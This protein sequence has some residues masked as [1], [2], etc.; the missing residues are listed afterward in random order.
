VTDQDTSRTN[1][2]ASE[3]ES[4]LRYPG[5]RVVAAAFFGVMVGY[6]VL[7]PYTFSLFIK[8]LGTEFGWRRDQISVAL[9]CVAIT[10]AICSPLIGRLLDVFGPRRTILPCLMIFGLGFASLSFLTPSLLRFNLTFILLGLAGN[11]TTQLAYSRA[12][13]TWFFARRGMALSLV[14]AGAGAGAMILPLL[15]SWVLRTSGWRT[16]YGVLGLLVLAVGVPLTS[17][18]VRESQRTL[19]ER[20]RSSAPEST[21]S[22][23]WTRPFLLLVA[24]IFFYSV[25]FNGMI[26]HLS[27]LLTDRG[28]SLA[29]SAQALSV[30]GASGLVG[31]LATGLLLDRFFVVR[32]SLLFFAATAAGIVFLSLS[33]APSAFLGSAIIGFAAG[34]ES[35]ITPYLLSR[36][37]SL[38]RFST[39]YGIAWTAFAAGT[40]LGP[41]LMGRL[42]TS[43]G[44]YQPWGIE[45]FALPTLLSAVLMILMPPYP[46]EVDPSRADPEPP[47]PA[48]SHAVL[49]E[50]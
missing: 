11:G 7:I 43:T 23:L 29:T 28:I 2:I 46:A 40:A 34:G 41:V 39:L 4:S 35:D 9:G 25:S 19:P 48:P 10:I 3:C 14:S 38:R 21:R 16:S 15:A 31:R 30:M 1:S 45:L 27:A 5:W 17:V 49:S 26:S 42:Y 18:L 44:G 47:I 24:A 33:S 20:L 6:S 36:Y 37:F 13:S 8:P 12:V 50:I 32:V 22:S